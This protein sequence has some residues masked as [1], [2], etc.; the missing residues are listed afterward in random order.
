MV[1]TSV[2]RKSKKCILTDL[3]PHPREQK[4]CR[5]PKQ[6]HEL[7]ISYKVPLGE[8]YLNNQKSEKCKQTLY[9]GK[10]VGK[11]NYFVYR[12]DRMFSWLQNGL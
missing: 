5:F 9:L 2:D 11:I 12:S 6:N 1:I 4:Y 7:H 10:T 8:H 3:F